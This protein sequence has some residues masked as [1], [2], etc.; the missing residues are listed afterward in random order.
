[1]S[2]LDRFKN[3]VNSNRIENE[4]V[5]NASRKEQQQ[6]QSNNVSPSNIA[7]EDQN[8]KVYVEQTQHKREKRFKIQDHLFLIKIETKRSKKMP[9][10]IN[11][12]DVLHAS[13][14]H[15]LD[16]IKSFYVKGRYLII[17]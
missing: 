15:I 10:L 13:L 14:R 5:Y 6:Q 4:T 17:F 16:E 8:F 11:I 2:F 7:Y 9:L 3:F 1:M 12:L